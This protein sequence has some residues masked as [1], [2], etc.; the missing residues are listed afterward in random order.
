[1]QFISVILKTMKGLFWDTKVLQKEIM[2]QGN[3]MY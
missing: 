3:P 1:M 2:I